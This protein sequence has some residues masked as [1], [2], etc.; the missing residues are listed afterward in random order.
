MDNF[1]NR[2]FSFFS[3]FLFAFR[4]AFNLFFSESSLS[5]SSGTDGLN[6]Y[7]PPVS[8][9]VCLFGI[10]VDSFFISS[11]SSDISESQ[12]FELASN[13]DSDMLTTPV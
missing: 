6:C 11:S 8:A 1:F 4:S 7:R 10:F 3:A 5:L 12:L 2:F 9:F 13:E